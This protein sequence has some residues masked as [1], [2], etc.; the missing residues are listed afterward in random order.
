MDLLVV[1]TTVTLR[2]SVID[3]SCIMEGLVDV[4]SVVDDEPQSERLL[5]FF[6]AEFLP[7]LLSIGSFSSI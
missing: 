2:V 1:A 3:L 7:D 5:V 4:A 6:I